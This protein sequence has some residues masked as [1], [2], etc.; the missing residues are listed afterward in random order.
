M[1][2]SRAKRNGSI[3][4]LVLPA[5]TACFFSAPLMAQQARQPANQPVTPVVV[6]APPDYRFQQAVQQQKARD[7]VQQ[8]QLEQQLHQGVSDNARRPVVVAPT[9]P[10]QPVQ[11]PRLN[12]DSSSQQNLSNAYRQTPALPRVI[13][14]PLQPSADSDQ[15][16]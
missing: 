15:V 10:Q 6:A 8:S 9:L 16:H 3:F 11:T 5:V 14:K 13:P 7:Q 1:I 2:R 12:G 4:S